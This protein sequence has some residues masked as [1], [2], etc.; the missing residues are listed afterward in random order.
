MFRSATPAATAVNQ[1]GLLLSVV[2]VPGV[3]TTLTPN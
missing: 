1:A 2:T 3:V